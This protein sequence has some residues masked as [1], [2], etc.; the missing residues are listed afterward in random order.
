MK[1]L[2]T[3]IVM[4]TA[5]LVQAAT[6]N[7]PK[8]G[9]LVLADGTRYLVPAGARLGNPGRRPYAGAADADRVRAALRAL[10]QPLRIEFSH[11]FSTRRC[12][13]TTGTTYDEPYVYGWG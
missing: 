1:Y 4:L 2:L 9:V 5:G 7:L 8:G 10:R 3:V 13:A 11:G 6:V 12:I